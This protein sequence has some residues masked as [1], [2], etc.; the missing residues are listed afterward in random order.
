[1]RTPLVSLEQSGSSQRRALYRILH[2]LYLPGLRLE[3]GVII[4]W[5]RKS[6]RENLRTPI[7]RMQQGLDLTNLYTVRGQRVLSVHIFYP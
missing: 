2:L 5:L 6:S 4:E 3:I 7:K 1:M